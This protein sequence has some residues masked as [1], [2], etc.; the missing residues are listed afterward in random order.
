MIFEWIFVAKMGSLES[1]EPSWR[2][3]LVTIYEVPVLREKASEMR[4]KS[5]SKSHKNRAP[6][7]ILLR[8]LWLLVGVQILKIFL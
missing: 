6:G 5:V 2:S 4:V 1:R 3:I 8:I 7:A